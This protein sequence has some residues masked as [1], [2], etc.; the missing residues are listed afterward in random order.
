MGYYEDYAYEDYDD[1]EPTQEEYEGQEA[2]ESKMTGTK[3]SITFDTENFAKGIVRDV[4]NEVKEN[5]Y[6]EIVSEIK[7]GILESMK[8]EIRL[9]AG[10]IIKE[11]IDD[12]VQNEKITIGGNSFWDDEPLKEY[13][14]KEYAKKCIADAIKE[15][16][17]TVCTGYE[18]DR[19]SRSGYRSKSKTYEFDAYIRSQLAI[20]DDIKNYIDK[21]VI[22]IKDSVNKGVK[23]MFDSSTKQMLSESVLRVLMAN[24]TYQKIQSNIACI[25]DK[26]VD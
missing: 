21:Q 22:E 16:K 8:E 6:E 23:E 12:Y 18:K 1:E 13:S 15:G 20:G 19:Y 25:A 4:E 7:E 5:L 11:I 26:T 2:T 14:M 3:I 17:F 9:R 10:E 24:E